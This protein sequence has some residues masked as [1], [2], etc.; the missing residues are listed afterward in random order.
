MFKNT[1][2]V[3]KANACAWAL[4]GLLTAAAVNAQAPAPAVNLAYLECQL[5]VSPDSVTTLGPDL[6]GDKVNLFNGSL[7]FEHTDL[8]LSG[9]NAIPVAVIRRYSPGRS[10]VITGQFGDWDMET[11]R[12]G[13]TSSNLAG[14][15]SA[16]SASGR[17][18]RFSAPPGIS[19]GT[20]GSWGSA[21]TPGGKAAA[22]TNAHGISET[23]ASLASSPRTTG[24]ALI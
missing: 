5:P 14:W 16:N 23:D 4:L 8:S 7:E 15:V 12:I 19:A 24:R 11:P 10:V 9:N 22:S 20:S 17:C 21:S 13:G 18:G 3:Q 1:W 6:F 2:I